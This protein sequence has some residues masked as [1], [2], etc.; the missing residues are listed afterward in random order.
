MA[1]Y[2]SIDSKPDE[3]S[4][5]DPW[6]AQNRLTTLTTPSTLYFFAPSPSNRPWHMKIKAG[7][8]T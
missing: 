3:L 6:G 2:T 4:A 5:A 8:D 1:G 7:G